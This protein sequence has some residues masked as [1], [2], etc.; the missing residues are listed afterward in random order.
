[1][2]T[3][4]RGDHTARLGIPPAAGALRAH[5]ATAATLTCLMGSAVSSNTIEGEKG[6]MPAIDQEKMEKFVGRMLQ[7]LGGAMLVPLVLIGDRLGLYKAMCDGGALTPEELAKRT[8]TAERYVREWLSANAA[9]G[10]VEY[11]PT[12]GRFTLPAEQAAVF[13][14]DDSPVCM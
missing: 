7:D 8:G 1:A 14:A 5:R 4:H 6:P 12:A 9:A 10:Y 3:V 2:D 11:D 13:A